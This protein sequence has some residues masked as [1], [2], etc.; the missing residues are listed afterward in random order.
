MAVPDG[1]LDDLENERI[2]RDDILPAYL[3]LMPPARSVRKPVGIVLGGQMGAGKSRLI[4]A[5]RGTVTPRAVVVD[6]DLLRSFHP[7]YPDLKSVDPAA[8]VRVSAVD[9]G[10]WTE[11]LVSALAAR[12][13][14]LVVEGTMRRFEPF[15]DTA[16]LLRRSGY[17]VRVAVLAVDGRISW[18]ATVQWAEEM[19][20]LG[21]GMRTVERTLHDEAG[22][23]ML[24]TVD[25]ICASGFADRVA[26]HARDGAALLEM[27]AIDGAYPNPGVTRTT[28]LAERNRPWDERAVLE[29]D[30][31]WARILDLMTARA[32]PAGQVRA[33]VADR[34]RDMRELAS[35]PGAFVPGDGPS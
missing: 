26:V 12:R 25:R 6:A 4:R 11:K 35:A 30:V 27:R 28:I 22:A 5:L 20:A 15:R 17:E 9:S 24:E 10:R 2:F 19:A 33:V 18:Q 14:H 16:D 8:A 31:R 3:G 23:G 32:A 21:E 34:E 1:P 29:H 13:A 7:A